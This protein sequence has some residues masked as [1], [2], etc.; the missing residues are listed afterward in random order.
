[1]ANK[2]QLFGRLAA[3]TCGCIWGYTYVVMVILFRDFTP[4]EVQFFR[5][6][7][8]AVVLYLVYPKRMEQKTTW[9]QELLF[10]GAGLSGVTTYF[11]LQGIAVLNSSASNVAVIVAV[12]PVFTALL[13][14]K[15]LGEARPTRTFFIGA[16]LALSGIGLISFAGSQLELNPLGDLIAVFTAL[17][18]A[19]YSIIAR[20][21]GGFGLHI[22]PVT[23]RIILYG[24][25]FLIPAMIAM[26]FRLE[27]ERF[28]YLPNLTGTLYLG[29][30]AS[31]A[32]Y[33]LWNFAV[34]TL[35]P[36]RTSVFFYFVP[37][38]GVAGSVLVLGETLT[39]MRLLGI[40][41]TLGGLLLSNQWPQKKTETAVR[42]QRDETDGE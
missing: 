33:V 41:L 8:A 39:W 13:A 36:A 1:M 11:F 18:F 2:K 6:A 10:A 35:G 23:R 20:K 17:S 5:F 25:L 29:L 28:S 22:I 21:I 34:K 19:F 16:V 42:E 31:A 15:I 38:V 24:L 32:C 7:I 14:W 37:V 27:L 26:D 40:V 12:S 3:L 9:R 4:V 30:A